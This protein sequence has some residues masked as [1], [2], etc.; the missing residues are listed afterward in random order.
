MY[1]I[2]NNISVSP[3]ISECKL[4]VVC[5][6]SGGDVFGGMPAAGQ[7][8]VDEEAQ[9]HEVQQNDTRARWIH[10]K[11]SKLSTVSQ[12]VSLR[13]NKIIPFI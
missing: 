7:Y 10:G 5:Y 11:F 6:G 9:G 12:L 13:N 3:W 2:Q 8:G 4:Y 1:Y